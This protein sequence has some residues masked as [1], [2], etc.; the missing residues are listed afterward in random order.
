MSSLPLAAV[1]PVQRA[2]AFVAARSRGDREA[3][4]ALL[5]DFADDGERVVAFCLL[6][7]LAIRLLADADG[8]DV[9]AIASRL[10]V[11]I[12]QAGSRDAGPL[13]DCL[14]PAV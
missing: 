4:Q 2:A 6:S 7:E 9:D 1:E 14:P 8:G 3:A 13:P 10:A 11:Q 12:A 5:A